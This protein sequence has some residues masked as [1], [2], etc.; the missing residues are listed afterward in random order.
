MCQEKHSIF[1][2]PCYVCP[3]YHDAIIDD[4]QNFPQYFLFKHPES[5]FIK[6]CEKANGIFI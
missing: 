4:I 2:T 3:C 6:R 5:L 1:E